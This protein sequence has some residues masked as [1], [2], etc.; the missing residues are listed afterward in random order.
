M[1]H[2]HFSLI[3]HVCIF[4]EIFIPPWKVIRNSEGGGG[5]GGGESQK[6][7]QNR[8]YQRGGGRGQ[9]V[10]KNIVVEL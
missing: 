10:R 1:I 2:K 9:L 3:S 5:G 7:K 6:P 4:Q 8:N